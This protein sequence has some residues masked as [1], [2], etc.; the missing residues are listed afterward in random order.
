MYVTRHASRRGYQVMFVVVK[1]FEYNMLPLTRCNLL[2]INT[3]KEN[4][5]VK[6]K[7]KRKKADQLHYVKYKYSQV[8]L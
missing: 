4:A 6:E 8:I 3:D 5:L 7:K 2:R 1:T